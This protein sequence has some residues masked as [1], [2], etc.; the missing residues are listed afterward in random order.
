MMEAGNKKGGMRRPDDGK[1]R[2]GIA[3]I[4]AGQKAKGVQAL[5]TVTGQDGA[6]DLANLWMLFSR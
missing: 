6:Q 3:L 2:L 1:L 5:R 4:E